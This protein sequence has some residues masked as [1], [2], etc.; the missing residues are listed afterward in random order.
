MT[1][2]EHYREAER[3]LE[4]VDSEDLPRQAKALGVSALQAYATALAHTVAKAQV[5]ASLAVAA[6]SA[7]SAPMPNR[8]TKADADAWRE[9]TGA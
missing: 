9:V 1:G 7:T 8:A 6:A 3:L 4:R 5:H 2:P